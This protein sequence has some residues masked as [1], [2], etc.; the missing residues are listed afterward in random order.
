MGIRRNRRL[1]ISY[2]FGI[3]YRL[4]QKL[5]RNQRFRHMGNIRRLSGWHAEPH[6]QLPSP[7]RLALY[8]SSTSA[9]NAAT[10]EELKQA[11]EQQR[12]QVEQQSRQS[13]IFICNNLNRIFFFAGAAQ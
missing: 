10:R 5:I 13:E 8:H 4:F 12:Q 6:H 2:H 1:C 11:A 9:G 3:V 7:Y